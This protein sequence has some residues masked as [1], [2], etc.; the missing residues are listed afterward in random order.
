MNKTKQIPAEAESLEKP[1]VDCFRRHWIGGAGR[2][3]ISSCDKASGRGGSGSVSTALARN[4]TRP[5]SAC[6]AGTSL[7][8]TFSVRLVTG[9]ACARLDVPP[10]PCRLG[11]W[12]RDSRQA[13]VVVHV[14][15]NRAQLAMLK[16]FPWGDLAWIVAEPE[17]IIAFD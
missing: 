15:Q 6:R 13:D 12:R 5:L 14:F 1:I 16:D 3:Q 17:H 11:E 10:G 4:A 7:K 8:P 2:R 9:T